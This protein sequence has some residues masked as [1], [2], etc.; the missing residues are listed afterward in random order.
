LLAKVVAF[1]EVLVKSLL[2]REIPFAGN[3]AKAVPLLFQEVFQKK[4]WTIEIGIII[5]LCSAGRIVA[6]VVTGRIY[7]MLFKCEVIDKTSAAFQTI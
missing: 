3:T 4:I 2:G 7:D 1:S 6:C 5:I